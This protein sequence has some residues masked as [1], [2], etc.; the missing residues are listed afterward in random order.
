M[1]SRRSPKPGPPKQKPD[2]GQRRGQLS[3]ATAAGGGGSATMGRESGAREETAALARPRRTMTKP[4]S[5]ADG[6]ASLA[7][8]ARRAQGARSGLGVVFLGGAV[9][10][11]NAV[12][13]EA[14]VLPDGALD[15]VGRLRIG[16]Q[17]GLG[18]LPAL[19]E[20]HAVEGEPGA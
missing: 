5:L 15:L 10:V 1:E 18:V 6:P 9:V 13:D 11:E 16:L 20:P 12:G 14:G 17:I 3:G 8:D 19:P 2:A 4:G 7:R